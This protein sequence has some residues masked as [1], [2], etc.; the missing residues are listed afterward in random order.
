MP[1]TKSVYAT[2][3]TGKNVHKKFHTLFLEGSNNEKTYIDS[4]VL[5]DLAYSAAVSKEA[6]ESIFFT[7]DAVLDL[8]STDGL[9]IAEK[10]INIM[11]KLPEVLSKGT[12]KVLIRHR[13]IPNKFTSNSMFFGSLLS[14]QDVDQVAVARI[15]QEFYNKIHASAQ[16]PMIITQ[17]FHKFLHAFPDISAEVKQSIAEAMD[18]INLPGG[19][20]I[21]K[22]PNKNIIVANGRVLDIDISLNSFDIE[23]LIDVEKQRAKS[24]TNIFRAHSSS[25]FELY[26]V[27][28]KASV[29]FSNTKVSEGRKNVQFFPSRFESNERVQGDKLHFEWNEESTEA[30]VDDRIMK[31]RYNFLVQ[32]CL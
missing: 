14:Q 26:S 16:E 8:E 11:A 28:M 7:I 12:D 31:V 13:I 2:L 3:L 29:Y 9:L 1:R 5:D 27:V 6:A 22:F 18:N 4:Q 32:I 23:L 25:E 17:E 30:F 20:E 24:L 21:S 19:G 15:L 10:F